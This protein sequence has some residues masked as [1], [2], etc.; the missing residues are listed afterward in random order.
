MNGEEGRSRRREQHGPVCSRAEQSAMCSRCRAV[1]TGCPGP[2]CQL[3]CLGFLPRT[4]GLPSLPGLP[5]HPIS[6]LGTCP[7]PRPPLQPQAESARKGTARSPVQGQLGPTQGRMAEGRSGPARAVAQA[8]SPQP[9]QTQPG[10][11]GHGL[12]LAPAGAAG[13]WAA[14]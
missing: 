1:W 2:R 11:S 8:S 10:G 9:S 13:S 6:A 3:S 5:G 14:E 7:A 12:P 4:V